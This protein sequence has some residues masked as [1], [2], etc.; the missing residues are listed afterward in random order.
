[1]YIK[2]KLKNKFVR[3][4]SLQSIGGGSQI[5]K[6]GIIKTRGAE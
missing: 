6:R 1:M 5:I 3:K 2:G 4:V